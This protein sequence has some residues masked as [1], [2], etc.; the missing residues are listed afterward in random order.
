[1]YQR[2][3][4]SIQQRALKRSPQS[5]ITTESHCFHMRQR[6]C[7]RKCIAGM[8]AAAPCLTDM[9][10]RSQPIAVVQGL[11]RTARPRKIGEGKEIAPHFFLNHINT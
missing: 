5:Q 9:L 6:S 2:N 11:Q 1:M 10:Q 8:A 3:T 4:W 7:C